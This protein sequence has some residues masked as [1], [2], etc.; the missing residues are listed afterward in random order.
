MRLFVVAFLVLTAPLSAVA[1][2]ELPRVLVLATGGTIAGEQ[3]EPGTQEGYEIRRPIGEVVNSVPEIR[4]YARVETEQFS[5]IPSPNI[6]P[7]QWLQ[8]ARRI[9][10]TFREKPELAGIVVTHGT[11]RL[12]ETA[13]FLNLTVKYD[14]PVVVVGAQRPPTGISPDGALNLLSAIR[15]AASP[16]ARGKGIL[17]VMD[18]KVLSARDA[19]K[20]YARNGGFDS[21]EMGTLGVVAPHGVEFFYAPVRRHTFRSEFDAAS[22]PE[23]P[24]VDIRYSYAGAD[25]IGSIEGVKGIVVATTGFTPAERTHYESLQRRGIIVAS[26]FPS[27]ENVGQLPSPREPAGT[28][29]VERLSPLHARIL[30]MLALTKTNDPVEVQRIFSQY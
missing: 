22:I 30:L 9:N 25:G 6:S 19:E 5:N 13:F 1:Q 28:I 14:R 20:I 2:V 24:F 27:G 8:L 7:V 17:V 26:T 3:R 15:V 18:E 29:A 21:G 4:K 12:E 16:D 23:L 11:A 10:N